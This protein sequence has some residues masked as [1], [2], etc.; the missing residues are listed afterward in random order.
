MKRIRF[1]RGADI[2]DARGYPA[3]QDK[4]D[5]TVKLDDGRE[6]P[7]F[8]FH[9]LESES[10]RTDRALRGRAV[11][12]TNEQAEEL[13]TLPFALFE[14]VTEDQ[15]SRDRYVRT[16]QRTGFGGYVDPATGLAVDRETLMAAGPAT[17]R[18]PTEVAPLTEGIGTPAQ[19]RAAAA[20]PADS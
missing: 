10:I 5:A 15:E 9:A 19:R 18:A 2:F 8:V 16:L 12:V 6:V 14:E 20:P 3:F 1:T 17:D 11:D 7:K 4:A 13:L